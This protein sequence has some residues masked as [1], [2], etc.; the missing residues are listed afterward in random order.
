[1]DRAAGFS[2]RQ[3]AR[4]DPRALRTV[5]ARP[6]CSQAAAARA[7]RVERDAW[8]RRL[9]RRRPLRGAPCAGKRLLR[10]SGAGTLRTCPQTGAPGAPP[11]PGFNVETATEG[12]GVTPVYFPEIFGA[13]TLRTCPYPPSPH[14]TP[15][16]RP[17]P[18]IPRKQ[19][20]I[21]ARMRSEV[22]RFCIGSGKE[23]HSG[24]VP[25]LVFRRHAGFIGIATKSR[26]CLNQRGPY[27]FFASSRLRRRNAYGEVTENMLFSEMK[28]PL[29][30]R[31]HEY[32][33]L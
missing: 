33:P 28:T 32:C 3:T 15:R 2:R 12:R 26:D 23:T 10:A 30:H 16:G 29:Q 8:P 11:A 24:I 21:R 19:I 20:R 1:V 5:A 18:G 17:R 14:E 7:P 25:T 9:Q 13:G 31:K 6:D 22:V 4:S 27:V